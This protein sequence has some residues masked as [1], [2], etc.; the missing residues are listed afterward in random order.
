MILFPP[1]ALF[2][3]TKLSSNNPTSVLQSSCS[4]NIKTEDLI[5]CRLFLFDQVVARFAINDTWFFPATSLHSAVFIL[6]TAIV[7]IPLTKQ[8]GER[9]LQSSKLG[10]NKHLIVA[11]PNSTR[12]TRHFFLTDLFVS[13]NEYYHSAFCMTPKQFPMQTNL[14]YLIILKQQ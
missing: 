6:W 11:T 12:D 1:I 13:V 7:K 3:S 14:K 8:G 4:E 9:S 5:P 2:L 10:A